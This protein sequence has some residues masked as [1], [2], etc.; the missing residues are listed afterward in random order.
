MQKIIR[1]W[2]LQSGSKQDERRGWLKW[3]LRKAQFTLNPRSPDRTALW[4]PL[5]FAVHVVGSRAILA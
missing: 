5:L 4:P 3:V 2:A 1:A